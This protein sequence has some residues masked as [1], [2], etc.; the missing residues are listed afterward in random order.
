M[1]SKAQLGGG[2]IPATPVT[3]TSLG[4]SSIVYT[5]SYGVPNVNATQYRVG[6]YSF[7][8]GGTT[9]HL[10]YGQTASGLQE[11]KPNLAS[12]FSVH[13][14]QVNGSS[15]LYYPCVEFQVTVGGKNLWIWHTLT[16]LGPAAS[17]VPGTT[18][19]TPASPPSRWFAVSGIVDGVLVHYDE[20]DLS[21]TFNDR[22]LIQR[23]S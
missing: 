11:H 8:Y 19:A 15:P 3:A 23:L 16:Q 14:Q 20:V 2:I 17:Q 12:G 13:C 10:G 18:L 7:T 9:Y 21:V 6:L 5:P 22:C 4:A 1:G